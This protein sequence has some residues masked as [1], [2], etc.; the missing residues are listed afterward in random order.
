MTEKDLIALGFERVDVTKEESG[1]TNDWYY[2]TY[3]LTKHLCLISNDNEEAK[4]TGWYVEFLDVES[5]IR[6]KSRIQLLDFI[7]LIENAKHWKSLN[8]KRN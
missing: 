3:D 7:T 2:F 4:E 5:E 6:F 1:Y 8:N